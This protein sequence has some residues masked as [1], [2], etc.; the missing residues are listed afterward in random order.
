MKKLILFLSFLLFAGVSFAQTPDCPYPSPIPQ[1]A[2]WRFTYKQCF[3]STLR[4]KY[5]DTSKV[6]Y[7]N[8]QGDLVTIT[9]AALLDSL[10][11]PGLDSTIF[12]TVH[13]VNER[14]EQSDSLANT[15]GMIFPWPDSFTYRP[16]FHVLVDPVTGEYFIDPTFDMRRHAGVQGTGV[17]YYVSVE[18]G[19][20]ANSGLTSALPLKTIGAALGKSDVS[21]IY[22]LPGYYYNRHSWRGIIPT[23]SI[24]LIGVGDSVVIT[25]DYR[26]VLTFTADGNLYKAFTD[27]VPASLWDRK[28][29]DQFGDAKTL[30]LYT[31]KAQVDTATVGAY[32]H[33]AANDTL[34]VRLPDFRAPDSL[35]CVFTPAFDIRMRGDGLNYYFRNF[36]LFGAALFTT[37]LT[38]LDGGLD[39]YV[40][41][42]TMRGGANIFDGTGEVMLFN[43]SVA[44]I[45]N[46]DLI[47]YDPQNGVIPNFVE[48]NVNAYNTMD[49]DYTPGGSDQASTAHNECKGIRINSRYAYT[50]GQCVADVNGCQSWLIN[51]TA[52]SSITTS[53]ASYLFG[54]GAVFGRAW[55][56]D[57]KSF[58]VPPSGYDINSQGNQVV[59]FNYFTS[60]TYDFGTSGEIDSLY[61]FQLYD[62]YEA[63]M[64]FAA[65]RNAPKLPSVTDGQTLRGLGTTLVGSSHLFNNG[66]DVGIGTTTPGYDLEIRNDGPSVTFG[67]RTITGGAQI[68]MAWEGSATDWFAGCESSLRGNSWILTNSSL[69]SSNV[70]FM[71]S[72]D[73]RGS[74]NTTSQAHHLNV[75]GVTFSTSYRAGTRTVSTSLNDS[76][77]V[78]DASTGELKSR[79]SD[80]NTTTSAGTLAMG[81]RGYYT[82]TGTTSTWTLPAVA[83]NIGTRF[84]IINDGSGA[85][86]L[87]SN[88]GGNDI[89]F[90]GATMSTTNVSSDEVIEIYNNGINWV[91]LNRE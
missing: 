5:A 30:K 3:D 72:T 65:N 80:V 47:N 20:D 82:A 34:Y 69:G 88:A 70:D 64:V 57:C 33:N 42:L 19:S 28:F 32:Y 53:S 21:T 14:T 10:D 35:T 87:N 49:L 79:P 48:Y 1:S 23:R 31:S 18:T 84:Y 36:I 62:P 85:V 66:V 59:H 63:A 61:H 76:N 2:K 75:G 9:Y 58:N 77:A 60:T 43:T 56:Q 38:G 27:T 22:V 39:I 54:T 45:K 40:D 44:K 67:L 41:S 29:T 37:N 6:A 7:V 71:V 51:C 4:L 78:W 15:K 81:Q 74:F 52:D 73:G 25:N 91:I 68:I 16:P 17:S 86:T 26:D 89:W 13:Y 24:E 83:G 12:A 55:L 50:V 8:G 46:G 11:V 90:E